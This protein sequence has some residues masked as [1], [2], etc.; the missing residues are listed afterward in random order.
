MDQPVD[1]IFNLDKCS[2]VGQISDATMHARSNL[3]TFVQCLPWV[4]LN[5][6]HA[7]ADPPSFW[8]D[9]QHFHLYHVPWVYQLTGMLYTFGPAHL[10]NVY[11]SFDAIFKFDEGPEAIARK[12]LEYLHEVFGVKKSKPM[13]QAGS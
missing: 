6:F 12:S 5:L 7:E 9:A 3:I 11:K 1:S 8:I 4:V 13:E 2:K 10:R